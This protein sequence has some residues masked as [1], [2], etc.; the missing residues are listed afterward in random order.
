MTFGTQQLALITTQNRNTQI[1]ARTVSQTFSRLANYKIKN[2][3]MF[4][5]RA[6]RLVKKVMVPIVSIALSQLCK[7]RV[8]AHLR[9]HGP[10]PAVSCRHS[11]VMWAVGHTSPTYCLY[12]PG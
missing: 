1:H 6:D 12:L 2:V 8:G 11:S 4:K 7:I 9:L 3:N 5:N 10:E